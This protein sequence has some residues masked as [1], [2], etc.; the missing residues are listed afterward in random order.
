MSDA[1]GRG[2]LLLFFKALADKSRLRLLGLLAQREHSVQELAALAGLKEPTVSHH[3]GMLK[4]LGL[5]SRRRDANTHWYALEPDAITGLAKRL[6]SPEQIAGLAGDAP[7]S[8]CQETA[9]ETLLPPAGHI[10]STP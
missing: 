10:T 3:L 5:V 6:S 9:H 4:R 7:A 1:N 8:D 2:D